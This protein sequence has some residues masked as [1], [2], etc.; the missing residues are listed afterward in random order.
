M[1]L[2]QNSFL[3]LFHELLVHWSRPKYYRFIYQY[4][5][6]FQNILHE[7]SGGSLIQITNA[8]RFE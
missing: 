7:K 3:K 1:L 8:R 2:K 5:H 6:P 4:I